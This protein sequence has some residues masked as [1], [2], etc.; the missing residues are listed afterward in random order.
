[1]LVPRIERMQTS[2]AQPLFRVAGL[3]SLSDFST[4]QREM[5]GLR[6]PC[7]SMDGLIDLVKQKARRHMAELHSLQWEP[8]QDLPSDW[9]SSLVDRS[10][11]SMV[12]AW[13]EQS[14][15]LREQDL[16]KNFLAKLQRQW[17]IETGVIEGIYSLSEGATM[18]LIE[19]GLDASLIGHE[20]T[21]GDPSDVV[22]KI[23]DQHRAIMGL[24]QFVSGQ[25]Q[26]GTSYVKELHQA[27]T[28]HQPTYVGR[29]T[30]GNLVE[31]DLPRGLWKTLP[32]NVEHPD[33]T[34]FEYCP[35][36]HV[37]QEMENLIAIHLSHVGDQVPPDIEAAWLHHR[38][39]LIHPFTDGNGRVARCLATLVLL[40]DYWLPLVVTRRDRTDYI[41]A[42]R[43]ADR[44]NLKP[45]VDQIGSLQRKAIRQ[46]LSL[47]E[48]VL[49]EAL[50]MDHIL[51]AVKA[52]FSR[53]RAEKTAKVNRALA[54][55]DSLQT[56]AS[57]RL[58]DV[59]HD[60]QSTFT[61]E[62]VKYKAYMY[63]GTRGQANAGYHRYQI[64][65]CAKDLGYFAD[66][67]RYQSWSSLA[68]VLDQRTEIL[69]SFHGIGR[70]ETGVLGCV[71][72]VYSKEEK[73]ENGEK[74][75]SDI[76]PLTDEPF[77]FSYVEDSSDVQQRFRIWLDR[78]VLL[79]LNY[80]QKSL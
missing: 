69:F 24:Y 11:S 32:N 17:A 3:R 28:A 39:T 1:M 40:K 34:G 45:L 61:G 25:R 63:Q 21:D 2:T 49:Q 41:A 4:T 36:E 48:D 44:G 65:Q 20:D 74:N 57:Q 80:W 30:L 22:A 50:A 16:Y 78:C 68:I 60:L 46:A 58:K 7:L 9:Q 75:I 23:Q 12:Q 56:L 13:K 71:A 8:I 51:N 73:T 52:K 14:E 6:W 19:K 72:M 67:R 70:E 64:V 54:T 79:G 15:H 27:L 62:G 77:E 31:R 29:D 47:S 38:F 66:L 59:E 42:L 26:L 35:P 43:S 18:T 53:E 33:G 55:A 37:D 5:S 10:T 76:H